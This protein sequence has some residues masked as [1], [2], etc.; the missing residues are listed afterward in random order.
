MARLGELDPGK[1]KEVQQVIDKESAHLYDLEVK[2]FEREQKKWERQKKKHDQGQK[3]R[4]DKAEKK[5]KSEQK[6]QKDKESEKMPIIDYRTPAKIPEEKKFEEPEAEDF[7]P[8]PKPPVKP[9]RYDAIR[10]KGRAR[11]EEVLRR[12]QAGDF[13]CSPD[14]TMARTAV[15]YG[16]EPPSVEP[17]PEWGQVGKFDLTPEDFNLILATARMQLKAPLHTEG[18]SGMPKDQ[19][20]RSALDLALKET[21]YIVDPLTYNQLLSKLTGAK[22]QTGGTVPGV[23]AGDSTFNPPSRGDKT[24]KKLSAEQSKAASTV[25]ARMDQISEY[26]QKNYAGLG[27]EFDEAKKVVNALDMCADDF[28]KAAFGEESFEHRRQEVMAANKE[29]EV[30]QRDSDE[31]YMD[32]FNNPS[33][34]KQTDS[35]EP[36]MSTYNTD[37][38]TEVVEGEDEKGED[39]TPNYDG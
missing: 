9:P 28:E 10:G 23:V 12:F 30:I 18:T 15:Y 8:P 24:M 29:A 34:T 38:T 1:A 4:R 19:W 35:D 7:R 31:P 6:K 3:A 20:F 37:G 17:Y 27:I 39:L 16:V 25:L 32:A 5:W 2:K 36:Y 21:G 11:A 22:D 13:I 14:R 26:L 33:G